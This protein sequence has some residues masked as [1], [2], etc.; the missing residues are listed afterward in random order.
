MSENMQLYFEDKNNYEG[1][2]GCEI[3]LGRVALCIELLHQPTRV[4]LFICH[5]I[6]RHLSSRCK[7]VC[8]NYNDVI[9]TNQLTIE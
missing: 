4:T 5:T 8:L 6:E 7:N 3:F 2:R 9:I 1:K